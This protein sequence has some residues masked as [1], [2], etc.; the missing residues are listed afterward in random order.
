MHS[1]ASLLLLRGRYMQTGYCWCGEGGYC[2]WYLEDGDSLLSRIKTIWCYSAE[3][4][5]LPPYVTFLSR[6]FN[7]HSVGSL[8]SING[9]IWN[10]HW[11]FLFSLCNYIQYGWLY[12]RNS[13]KSF[14]T[15]ELIQDCCSN[16]MD[17]YERM[18]PRWVKMVMEG[19]R[20]ALLS[21][22]SFI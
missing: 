20:D 14:L 15:F 13:D 8:G 4:R 19:A 6:V 2:K 12:T 17:R 10:D 18:H 1:Y 21:S 5:V 9:R 11:T 16:A 22:Y 7:S 3:N